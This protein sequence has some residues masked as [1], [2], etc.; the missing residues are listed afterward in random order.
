MGIHSTVEVRI[1]LPAP[2]AGIAQLVEA[3]N[4][5]DLGYCS[6]LL[7]GRPCIISSTEQ[8]WEVTGSS[9]VLASAYTVCVYRPR[10]P[11][12]SRRVGE[13]ASQPDS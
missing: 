7:I 2:R 8:S 12:T 11:C 1:L 6:S 10:S 9:P 13:M 5:S 3:L 4:P